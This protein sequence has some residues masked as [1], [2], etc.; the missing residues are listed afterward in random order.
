MSDGWSWATW[1]ETL[2]LLSDPQA[3]AEIAEAREAAA[4]GEGLDAEALRARYL[5]GRPRS[6]SW[7]AAL[8]SQ[9]T[10]P[11]G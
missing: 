6:S 1:E 9:L 4:R 5:R 11:R 8:A 2:E 10:N 7:V 3:L